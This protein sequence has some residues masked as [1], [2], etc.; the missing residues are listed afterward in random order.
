[1]PRAGD[2]F[3][4]PSARI[5][6]RLRAHPS[7][8]R[9]LFRVPSPHAPRPRPFGP[10]FASPLGS[11]PSS[12]PH[13]R[14]ATIREASHTSLRSVLGFRSRS[15]VCSARALAGLFHPA[16]TSRVRSVQ[17]LLS[18][19]SHPSSSEGACPLAVAAP[20]LTRPPPLSRRRAGCHVRCLSA[21]RLRSAQGRVPRV[22]LFTSP[23]AAPLFSSLLLQV[24]F[25]S[26]RRLR[27]PAAFRPWC[28][29]ARP[30]HLLV[31]ARS[32]FACLASTRALRSV[33]PVHLRRVAVESLRSSRLRSTDP[34]R[35]F[36]P[37]IRDPAFARSQTPLS[38][39][40]RPRF[41]EIP[42]PAFARSQTPLSRESQTTRPFCFSHP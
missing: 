2:V 42:D 4:L 15:T 18:P 10:S 21:S 19:R 16:A 1:M 9:R 28:S 6:L 39:D 14:A 3:D 38:R 5:L 34:A 36:E 22:R 37:F 12:R 41:R 7:L 27:L 23:A 40:P 35:A 26:R 33:E 8:M 24:P 17:G 11:R 32:A 30:S 25:F 29:R 13:A 31:S 20:S